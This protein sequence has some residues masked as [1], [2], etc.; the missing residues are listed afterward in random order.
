MYSAVSYTS[1]SYTYRK[2]RRR[3][4]QQQCAAAAAAAE[5]SRAAEQSSYVESYTLT[6]DSTPTTTRL[7][8]SPSRIRGRTLRAC[9]GADAH[10]VYAHP[11]T[12]VVLFRTHSYSNC[13]RTSASCCPF[14]SSRRQRGRYIVIVIGSSS[15]PAVFL[16][17][18]QSP[19]NSVL[20][21]RDV[22]CINC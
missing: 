2:V 5:Q 3:C 13:R 21:Q 15:S 1:V 7:P 18:F 19:L 20:G 4:A 16:I 14:Y 11:Y 17:P 6:V 10:V 9:V 8:P 12:T 22:P